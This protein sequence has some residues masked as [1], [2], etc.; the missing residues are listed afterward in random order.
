MFDSHLKSLADEVARQHDEM[1][2][3]CFLVCGF[4]TDY[5]L[6]HADEFWREVYSD[7]REVYYRGKN[8]LFAVSQN[9][10]TDLDN[11]RLTVT[12]KVEWP[13]PEGEKKDE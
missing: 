9:I 11:H 5:L 10:E 13:E 6:E 1:V 7:C 2:K 3:S 4:D 8:P 12:Q